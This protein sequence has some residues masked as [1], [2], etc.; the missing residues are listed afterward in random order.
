MINRL[1]DRLL[2]QELFAGL[3][4]EGRKGANVAPRGIFHLSG[5]L[6]RIKILRWLGRRRMEPELRT[7][8]EIEVRCK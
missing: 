4:C 7:S 2:C 5:R 3:S 1:E 6:E 8:I